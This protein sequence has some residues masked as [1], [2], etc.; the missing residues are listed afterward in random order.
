LG[1]PHWLDGRVGARVPRRAPAAAANEFITV[2]VGV[3]VI[4]F[5]VVFFVVVTIIVA[6]AAVSK[7]LG[8]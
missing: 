4:D 7:W 6:V 2:G 8:W 1:G 5:F 3:I